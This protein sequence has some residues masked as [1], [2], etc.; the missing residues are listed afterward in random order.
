MQAALIVVLI[1]IF[2]PIVLGPFAVKASFRISRN[3]GIN[4]LAAEGLS[5]GIK[6]YIDGARSDLESLGYSFI[7]YFSI[8][9]FTPGLETFFGLFRND[10]EKNGAM[11]AVIKTKQGKENR[12][13]EFTTKSKD[14]YTIN[15]NNA[16]TR[17]TQTNPNKKTCRFPK[18]TSIRQLCEINGWIVHHDEKAGFQDRLSPPGREIDTLNTYMIRDLDA[19]VAAGYYYLDTS[20][21]EYLLTWKGAFVFTE[22]N[23]FPVKNILAWLDER[24][25]QK[26]IAGMPERRDFKA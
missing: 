10:G 8:L 18:V 19:H 12:Y 16:K 24:R 2:M 5:P 13:I 15:V 7:G 20:S 26:A 4:P 21:Q 25:A 14:D 9:N 11:A 22:S 6:S 17:G 1:V 23:A 3:F